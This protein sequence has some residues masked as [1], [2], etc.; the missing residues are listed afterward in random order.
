MKILVKS[1]AGGNFH[2]DVEPSDTVRE[3]N[4]DARWLL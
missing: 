1:L 3:A 4:T 2:L